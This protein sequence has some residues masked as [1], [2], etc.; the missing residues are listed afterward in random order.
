D[1][2][3]MSNAEIKNIPIPALS[4]V[5]LCKSITLSHC[6]RHVELQDVIAIILHA[7]NNGKEFCLTV[8]MS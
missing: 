4:S 7:V 3:S 8:R 6:S 2:N 5:F 1:S